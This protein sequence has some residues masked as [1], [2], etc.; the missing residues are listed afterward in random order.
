MGADRPRLT[1]TWR[2]AQSGLRRVG[3]RRWIR[4]VALQRDHGPNRLDYPEGPGACEEAVD[5]RQGTAASEGEDEA[6][7]ASF[8]RVHQNH[9]RDGAG[10]EESEHTQECAS[11]IVLLWP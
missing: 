8:Q 1:H 9:E 10:T 2:R 6:S 3:V 7:A 11:A 5:A 4:S